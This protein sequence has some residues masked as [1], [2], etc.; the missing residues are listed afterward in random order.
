M[1]KGRLY[2]SAHGEILGVCKGI[3][4]WMQMPVDYV[5][6]GVVLLAL[7][8]AFVPVLIAYIVLGVVLPVNEDDYSSFSDFERKRNRKWGRGVDVRDVKREFDHLKKRVNK[9]ESSVFD[10]EKDWDDRF[11]ES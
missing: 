11:K 10:K 2:R 5:R 3:A 9:M 1:S 7:F 4:E 8:T 6:V